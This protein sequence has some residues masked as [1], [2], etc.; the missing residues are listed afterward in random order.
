MGPCK[1]PASPWRVHRSAYDPSIFWLVVEG[2]IA[3]IE[4]PALCHRARALLVRNEKR[5]IS[6]DLSALGDPDV[7]TVG[8][9][10]RLH[11]TAKQAGGEIRLCKASK[12]LLDL[13]DL[14]GL[15]DVLIFEVRPHR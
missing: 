14:A 12:K 11:L 6:C 5:A 2:P 1:Q 7:D 4:I 9:L 15:S 10:A 8:A 13:L 3:P